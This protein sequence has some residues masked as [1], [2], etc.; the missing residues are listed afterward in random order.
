MDAAVASYSAPHLQLRPAPRTHLKVKSRFGRMRK[1]KLRRCENA[2]LVVLWLKRRYMLDARQPSMR[3]QSAKVKKRPSTRSCTTILALWSD[4]EHSLQQACSVESER[5]PWLHHRHLRAG[6]I[7]GR[8]HEPRTLSLESVSLIWHGC[9]VIVRASHLQ[10]L[11]P[12][13]RSPRC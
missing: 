2:F 13:H 4:S 8:A 9:L 1:Q 12:Y 10:L 11:E 3:Q 5:Q 7:C 6:R